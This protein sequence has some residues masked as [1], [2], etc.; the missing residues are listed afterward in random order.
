MIDSYRNVPEGG[1]P[2]KIKDLREN[3]LK[4]EK[5]LT[6]RLQVLNTYFQQAQLDFC[7]KVIRE[8]FNLDL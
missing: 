4:Q 7:N 3:M 5:I 1:E 2:N 6:Q 8:R